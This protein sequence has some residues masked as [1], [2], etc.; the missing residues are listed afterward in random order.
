MKIKPYHGLV[1][2]LKSGRYEFLTYHRHDINTT[3]DVD[4]LTW[5]SELESSHPGK[6]QPIKGAF[7]YITVTYPHESVSA[8]VRLGS[9]VVAK[10]YKTY[11]IGCKAI[12]SSDDRNAGVLILAPDYSLAI[13]SLDVELLLESLIELEKDFFIVYK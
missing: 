2:N 8:D 12:S 9:V 4:Y 10:V 6:Y 7:G 5:L 3:I 1:K 13:P 11:Q